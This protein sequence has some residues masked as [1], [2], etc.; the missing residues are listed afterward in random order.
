M[1]QQI[2]KIT[3]I[4]LNGTNYLP[5]VHTVTI[6]LGGRSKLE[7]LTRKLP[8]PEPVNPNFPTAQEKRH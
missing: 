4:I 5:W 8:K 3:H 1:S 2:E 7:Y 6:E